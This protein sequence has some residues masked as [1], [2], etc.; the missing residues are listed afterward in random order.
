MPR[1]ITQEQAA[2]IAGVTQ[3]AIA[4]LRKSDHWDFFEGSKVDTQSPSWDIYLRGR[5]IFATDENEDPDDLTEIENDNGDD[6]EYE[7]LE[8]LNEELKKQHREAD[9]KYKR[10]RAER[11]TKRATKEGILL[12]RLEGEVLELRF[13]ESIFF[14]YLGLLHKQ[15]LS[16]PQHLVDR[17]V[18]IA[19][20]NDPDARQTIVDLLTKETERYLAQCKDEVKRGLDR[21]IQELDL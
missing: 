20:S 6:D 12:K 3:S 8:A 19:Q 4:H 13:V 15:F 11:E 5:D 9:L 17:I 7:D 18:Q 2:K 1:L 14:Q 10:A 21:Y 16:M